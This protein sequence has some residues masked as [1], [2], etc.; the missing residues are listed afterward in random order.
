M[1]VLKRRFSLLRSFNF[2]VPPF[3]ACLKIHS[4]HLHAPLRGIFVP[5]SLN[6]ARCA[7]FI[8][9]KSPTKWHAQLPESNFQTRSS[10]AICLWNVSF[11]IVFMKIFP[12][13][14]AFAVI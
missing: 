14:G 1:L 8:W 5:N 9:H 3:R 4:W 11:F 7:A 10:G 6:A 13:C 12:L 2:Y